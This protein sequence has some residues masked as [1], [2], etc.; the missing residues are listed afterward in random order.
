MERP[1]RST[2]RP[3][4]H[5]TPVALNSPDQQHPAARAAREVPQAN[6]DVS[7]P[8]AQGVTAVAHTRRP[9]PLRALDA[10]CLGLALAACA[11]VKLAPPLRRHAPGSSPDPPR[12]PRRLWKTH[13]R[14]RLTHRSF[15]SLRRPLI[16]SSPS[17]APA[18][19]APP[20]YL[21]PNRPGTLLRLTAGPFTVS[22]GRLVGPRGRL[23]TPS[24]SPCGGCRR[25]QVDHSSQDLLRV[26]VFSCALTTIVVSARDPGAC[27]AC[28]CPGSSGCTSI[29]DQAWPFL[30]LPDTIE[31]APSCKN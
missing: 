22:P 31:H 26:M 29:L 27:P 8:P 1:Y 11:F 24:F 20:R 4:D 14:S 10:W 9:R 7:A 6:S 28:P 19:V 21:H 18:S 17:A 15:V 16:A 30:L 25:R 23:R 5:G 12:P 13:S 3:L 2:P